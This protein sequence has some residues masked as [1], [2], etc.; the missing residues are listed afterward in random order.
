MWKI[1]RQLTAIS[2][3]QILAATDL[4]MIGWWQGLSHDG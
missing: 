2:L 3:K 1:H 4:K